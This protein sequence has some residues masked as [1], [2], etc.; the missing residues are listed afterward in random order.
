MTTLFEVFRLA[1][2]IYEYEFDGP[3][4]DFNNLKSEAGIY[5]VMV[6][7]DNG[8]RLLDMGESE[9]IVQNLSTHK[10]QSEWDL[11]SKKKARAFAALYE[12]DTQARKDIQEKLREKARPPCG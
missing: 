11:Y 8:W 9:N 3:Y 2:V 1:I 7:K 12:Q 6:W 5:A 4:N 10:R